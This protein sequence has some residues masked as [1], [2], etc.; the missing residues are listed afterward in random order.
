MYIYYTSSTD[1]YVLVSGSLNVLSTRSPEM[2]VMRMARNCDDFQAVL[3]PTLNSL[4][5]EQYAPKVPRRARD[6]LPGFCAHAQF[7]FGE[8]VSDTSFFLAVPVNL[9]L[10]FVLIALKARNDDRG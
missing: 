3:R 5:T 9:F 1:C 2:V 10:D 7:C 8:G 6:K 4:T